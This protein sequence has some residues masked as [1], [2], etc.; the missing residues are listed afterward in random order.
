M[1]GKEEW[2]CQKPMISSTRCA[3]LKLNSKNM[4][5]AFAG[6]SS[7]RDQVKRNSVKDTDVRCL[8]EFCSYIRSILHGRDPV[9]FLRN[10]KKCCHFTLAEILSSSI[11]IRVKGL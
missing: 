9:N 7:T 4:A 1:R 3:L 5:R 11:I 10:G 6:I 8:N 2:S